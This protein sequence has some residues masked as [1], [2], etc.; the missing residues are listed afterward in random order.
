VLAGE[1]VLGP[2]GVRGQQVWVRELGGS[3]E[4]HSGDRRIAEHEQAPRRHTVVRHPEHHEGIA[5]GARQQRKTLVH[6]RSQAP[7]A[8]IRPRDAY[9]SVALGGERGA[10]SSACARRWGVGRCR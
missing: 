2:V 1:P 9:E 5:L 10:R 4:I 6:I 8:E 7:V 3:V